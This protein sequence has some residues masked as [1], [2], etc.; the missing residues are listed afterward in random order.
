MMISGFRKLVTVLRYDGKPELMADGTYR[1]PDATELEVMAS[2]QALKANEMDVLPEGTRQARAVKIYT[3]VELYTSDQHT[4]TPADRIKWRG[5]TFEIV[6]SDIFQ[7]DVINH[8]RSYA[9]EVSEF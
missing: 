3:D 5:R 7:N 4:N 8:Y 9:V 1:Y 2:V 6:A